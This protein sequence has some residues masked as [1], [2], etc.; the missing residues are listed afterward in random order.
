MSIWGVEEGSPLTNRHT[1][2]Q[3]KGIPTRIGAIKCT[4]G[5]ADHANLNEDASIS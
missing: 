2:P 4:D 3:P 5:R 1:S